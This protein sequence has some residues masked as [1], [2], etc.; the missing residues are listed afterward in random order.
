MSAAER[1]APV[2][3]AEAKT[4]F[5]DL[6]SAPALLLAV[7]GGPDSTALMVLAARWRVALAN[8]PTLIAVTVDH[9]LRAQS[10]REAESNPRHLAAARSGVIL[11][12]VTRTGLPIRWQWCVLLVFAG[13]VDLKGMKGATSAPSPDQD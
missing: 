9:G 13:Q 2:S 11:P 1:P 8:G 3:A 10:R 12:P 6:R 4:L 5:A 7:S